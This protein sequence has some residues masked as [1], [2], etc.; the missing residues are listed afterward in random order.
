[1]KRI[2]STV[3]AGVVAGVFAFTG[4]VPAS[5][6]ARTRSLH[7]TKECSQ[8]TGAAGSF[9]TI[10]TSNVRAI[11]PGSR[12]IYKSA[13]GATS[14][15]TDIVLRTGHGNRAFGHVVLDFVTGTGTVR[16]NGGTG[17]FRHFHAAAAVSYIAGVDWAWQGTYKFRCHG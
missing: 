9:C 17:R 6:A 14:L 16:L 12:V 11:K 4:L 10:T 7:I 5:A 2:L 15:D 1:M 8:Y 13:A 3:I